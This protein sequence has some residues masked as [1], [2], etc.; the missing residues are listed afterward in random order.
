MLKI[1]Q[2]RQNILSRCV[3]SASKRLLTTSN[4]LCKDN[5]KTSVLHD[6]HV[7]NNAKMV[8]F[9]GWTMPIQYK[10]LGIIDSHHHT[11]NKVSL[12]DV[13]HMLQFKVY[14]KDKES[15]IES[16]TVCDVKGL[17]EN[18]GSL[19]VFTNAE[20]GIMDDAIINQTQQ[21]YLYCV[22]NA[23]CSDKISTCLRENL[24][25]FTAKG[26]EVV[27][28]LL[29]CGLLAVQGPK[30]AEVLQTGTDTDLSKL[31]FMQNVEAN[32][33]GVDCRITRCGYTGEDGVEISVAKNRAVEL[34]ENICSHEDV[35]LAGLGARDSLRLEAGLCLYGNDIDEMTTPV[36]AGLTWCI[37]K[38]RRKEKNFPGAE[39]IVAQIKSKPSKRRSGLIVSSAIARNGAIV[40]D[41]NGNEIG[42][43]TSGCPS[44]TL[45]ANIAM[46]YLPLPLS[47]VGTE[48]NVLVRKRV[49]SAK[50]TKMP[51]VPANYF[52]NK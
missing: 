28:E 33:F 52:M 43:V 10:S 38:R 23:G 11:R 46:A 17:P 5:I 15:F 12:F 32:L 7:K 3:L 26:G 41:G 50:V 18:G 14:G 47:K 37:G 4:C 35:E 48:V 45:S 49:V 1:A 9:A 24:I 31:Y 40:Q 34:A 2:F 30:M 25:D 20:G 51:F 6:F 16:M 29:D 19:T 42:S 13:S 8:P 21:D 39:K 36:E 22:S 44:P 27:L